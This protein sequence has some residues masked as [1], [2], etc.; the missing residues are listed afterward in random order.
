VFP[1]SKLNMPMIAE[2]YFFGKV[3]IFGIG[4]YHIYRA[5]RC[6]LHDRAIVSNRLMLLL[7]NNQSY[8]KYFLHHGIN[9]IIFGSFALLFAFIPI[10]GIF[11]LFCVSILL[12]F[13]S[14]LWCNKRCFDYFFTV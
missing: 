4:I 13:V 2:I 14:H 8:N 9:C 12:T 7:D 10:V 5:I 1:I 3:V 6:F 11:I